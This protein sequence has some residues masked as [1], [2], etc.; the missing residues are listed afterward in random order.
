MRAMMK[1]HVYKHTVC[2][3][4]RQMIEGT[5]IA[6][7][8]ALGVVDGNCYYSFLDRFAMKIENQRP[9]EQVMHRREYGETLYEVLVEA[10][11]V[12]AKL[13]VH[14]PDGLRGD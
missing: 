8:F 2:A 10:A 3:Y 12:D 1:V 9:L 5:A 6:A 11:L 7:K 13:A 4:A 14:N